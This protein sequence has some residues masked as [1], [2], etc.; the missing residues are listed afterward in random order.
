MEHEPD[1]I[2]LL[3]TTS[4]V[5]NVCDGRLTEDEC[6]CP[7]MA[8]RDQALAYLKKA[9]DKDWASMPRDSLRKLIELFERYDQQWWVLTEDHEREGS[10][11]LPLFKTNP[12]WY[13]AKALGDQLI[14]DWEKK[15][16]ELYA[17]IDTLL[18]QQEPKAKPEDASNVSS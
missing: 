12:A 17:R 4:A 15:R 14:A 3:F 13:E 9:A 16:E 8:A 7:V 1:A 2:R 6:P 18:K 5:C 10:L 11:G